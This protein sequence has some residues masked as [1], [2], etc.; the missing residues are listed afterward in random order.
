MREFLTSTQGFYVKMRE[1]K[2]T[3]EVS[4]RF[5]VSSLVYQLIMEAILLSKTRRV[6]RRSY[7]RS[8]GLF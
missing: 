1:I 6:S 4:L 7:Q 5:G 2:K 8:E 3:L